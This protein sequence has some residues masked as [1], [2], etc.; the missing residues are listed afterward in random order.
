MEPLQV[1]YN[2]PGMGSTRMPN[3]IAGQGTFATSPS[4]I[5]VVGYKSRDVSGLGALAVVASILLGAW[6]EFPMELILV[7]T[8]LIIAGVTA[9][10][11]TSKKQIQVHYAWDNVRSIR[12]D[13]PRGSV[14]LLVKGAKPKGELFIKHPKGSPLHDELQRHLA[15][16][17]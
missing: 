3:P 10:R 1:E 12:Y 15:G 5:D 8:G 16:K 7:A 4:G 6:L 13:D 14:V 2:P 9:L 17:R 11:F